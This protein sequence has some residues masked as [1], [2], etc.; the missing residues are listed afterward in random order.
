MQVRLRIILLFTALLLLA[1]GQLVVIPEAQQFKLFLFTLVILGVPHGALDLYIEQQNLQQ[2]GPDLRKILLRYLLNI[3]LYATLWYF[4]PLIALVVFILISA[5][6]FGEIDWLGKSDRWLQRLFYFSIGLCWLTHFL[7]TNINSAIQIFLY[8]GNAEI[9][10]AQWQQWANTL[11][12]LSLGALVLLYLISFFF[13]KYFFYQ[14]SHCYFALLQFFVLLAF[15]HYSSLWIGF[16][17]YFGLWHS[18]LSLDKIRMNF[19]MA[20]NLESW[21]FLLKKALPFS[22]MAWMGMLFV[23]F[24]FYSS[25][26]TTSLI[27]LVF[28][29]LSVLTLPHLQVFTKLRNQG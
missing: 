21:L 5:Y 2:D 1:L 18:L 9:T 15:C 24:A 19:S 4:A 25:T 27:T 29:T 13:R 7:A 16:G 10:T 23:M 8:L 6:H 11:A 12:P 17:F 26:Q 20:D 3:G 14:S 28:I 22:I